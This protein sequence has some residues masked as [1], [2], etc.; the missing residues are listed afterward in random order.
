[1]FLP[2]A[3]EILAALTDQLYQQQL[4][5]AAL[6]TSSTFDVRGK[7]LANQR[8]RKPND[9]NKRRSLRGGQSTWV[10][11][12]VEGSTWRNRGNSKSDLLV[13]SSKWDTIDLLDY[14][15]RVNGE[16]FALQNLFGHLPRF[17]RDQNGSRFLQKVLPK[18]DKVEFEQ[19]FNELAPVSNILMNH[20]FDNMALLSLVKELQGSVF[21]CA[22]DLNGNH[23]IQK[24]IER[25]DHE[26]I[27]FVFQGILEKVSVL[28]THQ[29]G[30]RVL[31]RIMERCSNTEYKTKIAVA[32][33]ENIVEL[34]KHQYGNYVVQHVIE[35]GNAQQ[36]ADAIQA[37][38]PHTGELSKHKFA[39]NV[40]E[41]CLLFG[42]L[43]EKKNLIGTIFD[44][45]EKIW[46]GLII[47]QFGNYVM[48][49]VLEVVS[50]EERKALLTRINKHFDSL[51]GCMYGK[52]I[53]KRVEKLLNNRDQINKSNLQHRPSTSSE[54][55]ENTLPVTVAEAKTE[56]F[57]KVEGEV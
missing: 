18:V 39:S 28:K 17:A 44:A 38:I 12:C 46:H 48:Q 31:Q 53:L 33:M 49:R 36:K 43:S 15:H 55:K 23:V 13:P 2:T 11:S 14:F 42:A 41:K 47:H 19:A 56:Q 30:C 9:M 52:H 3:E 51:K 37:L 29:Y 35:H 50:E 22:Q 20:V 6:L 54:T 21:E 8:S 7:V 24:C 27:D 1:M 16:G 26:K 4:L 10:P 32:T 57:E 34:A 45:D 40:I 5:T 25:L